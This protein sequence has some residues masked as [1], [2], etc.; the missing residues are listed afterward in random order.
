MIHSSK[1]ILQAHIKQSLCSNIHCKAEHL[2]VALKNYNYYLQTYIKYSESSQVKL[3]LDCICMYCRIYNMLSKY[4]HC[5]RLHNQLQNK[6]RVS[7]SQRENILS[8]VLEA[9]LVCYICLIYIYTNI[10]IRCQ[11]HNSVHII[12]I[13]ILPYISSIYQIKK[14]NHCC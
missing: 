9:S 10:I 7:Q 3:S 1:H 12:S 11:L 4:S 5:I 13:I 8:T 14:Q 2:K 6:N